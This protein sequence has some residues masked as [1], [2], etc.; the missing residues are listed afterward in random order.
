MKFKGALKYYINGLKYPLIIYYTA[1]LSIIILIDLFLI[2]LGANITGG[3][4][5]ATVI[6]LF[7]CGL[8][9]FKSAFRMFLANGVSRRTMFTGFIVT[10]AAAVLIMAL[11][12][13]IYGHVLTSFGWYKSLYFQLYGARYLGFSALS[14]QV[15]AEGFL[16]RLT[17]Y[18]ASVTAGYLIT[19]LYYRMNNAVKLT[20]SVGVPVIFGILLPYIDTSLLSGGISDF[21]KNAADFLYTRGYNPYIEILFFMILIAV[22]GALSFT[23]IRRAVIKN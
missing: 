21:L 9:S 17:A 12:D 16:W 6:F 13:S 3:F 10:A 8:N 23:A 18:A 22:F 15:F 20:V 5:M 11:I 19:L 2:N 14:V 4:E 1:I 7:V